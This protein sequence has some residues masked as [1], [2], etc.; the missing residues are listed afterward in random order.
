MANYTVIIQP[1][2]EFDLDEAHE[3]LESRK[4][5]LGFGLLEEITDL[6]T[7]LEDNPFVFQKV[8]KEKRRAVAKRFGYNLIFVIKK[9]EVYILAIIHGSRNPRK[10][11]DRK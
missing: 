2:A 8:H 10:W 4:K 7:I 1:E 3:Y 11:K 9:K 5:G 6:L